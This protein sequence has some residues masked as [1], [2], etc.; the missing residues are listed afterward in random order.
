MPDQT[1]NDVLS[2]LLARIYRSL[3]QYTVECWPWTTSS[4]SADGKSPEE[5][6]V[7]QMAARQLEFV[8]RLV[9]LLQGRGEVVDFGNYPDNSELHYVSLD[10]LLGKLI[11]DEQKLVG[12]LEAA[13]GAIRND[14]P[15]AGLVIELLAAE[16]E[17][18]NRLRE[19][20][21]KAAAAVSA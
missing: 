4:E 10:Y 7:E 9:N 14:P 1:H 15:A 8:G 11:A 19:L 18:V 3:L 2:R 13:R 20:A 21:G 17:N 6:T 5:K 12:E 16:Q